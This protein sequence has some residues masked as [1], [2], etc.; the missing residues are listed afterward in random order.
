[1]IARRCGK[2]AVCALAVWLPSAPAGAAPATSSAPPVEILIDPCVPLDPGPVLAIV[3]LELAGTTLG[4]SGASA[5]ATR[6]HLTCPEAE[7]VEIEVQDPLTGKSLV[8]PVSLVGIQPN[9]RAR[10]L[11]L[12]AAE[13]V[14][15]SWMELEVQARRGSG[16]RRAS[17]SNEVEAGAREV[18][19]A[20]MEPPLQDLQVGALLHARVLD[21]SAMLWGTGLRLS[22]ERPSRLGFATDVIYERGQR[23]F[24]PGRIHIDALSAAA[25]LQYRRTRGAVTVGLGAG[26]RGG[27]AWIYGETANAVLA[28]DD[29][30]AAPWGGP[31]LA[32]SG[33]LR[34]F[35][36]IAVELAAECGYALVAARGH[37]QDNSGIAPDSGALGL[38]G[39]WLGLS[40]ALGYGT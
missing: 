15:A 26:L 34:W 2:A 27:A 17:G 21:G 29:A 38:T 4:A 22:R 13:L 1:V 39:L 7:T 10:L 5:A 35:R 36:H 11:G 12:A 18:V 30:F 3:G 9:T 32:A 23:Q 37:V 6:V 28:G 24:L 16:A 31:L 40:L 20:R 8:R 19:R 25:L 33:G 14:T